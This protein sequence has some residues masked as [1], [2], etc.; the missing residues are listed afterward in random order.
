MKHLNSIANVQGCRDKKKRRNMQRCSKLG[1]ENTWDHRDPL[2]NR[3]D[4]QNHN[5]R[6]G[7]Q[8]KKISNIEI[9][10]VTHT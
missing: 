8:T 5:Q 3:R 2:L 6:Q 10:Q 9:C 7:Q 1:S 4:R